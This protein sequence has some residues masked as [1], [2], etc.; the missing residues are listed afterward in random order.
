MSLYTY[1]YHSKTS[2]LEV[3]KSVRRNSL[4]HFSALIS[5][6]LML[7]RVSESRISLPRSLN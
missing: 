6:T 2:S 1:T 7:T 5:N 3:I 4:S